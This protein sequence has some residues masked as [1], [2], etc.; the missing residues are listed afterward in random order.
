MKTHL[1]HKLALGLLLAG[2]LAAPAQIKANEQIYQKVLPG[3]VLVLTKDS[4]GTGVLVDAA[5]RRLITNYHVVR[6]ATEAH[7]FFPVKKNGNVVTDRMYYLQ[8]AGT[9]AIRGR[10]VARSVEADLAVIELD[11]LPEG[12]K[13]VKLAAAS[14]RPG[15]VLHAIGNP[16]TEPAM[17]LYATGK[18]RSVYKKRMVSGFAATDFRFTLDCRILATTIPVNPGD[19]GGPVVNDQGE[20]VGITQGW[21]PTSQQLGYAIDISEVRSF[22]SRA[23][24]GGSN[25]FA[26]IQDL[27]TNA[28]TTEPKQDAKKSFSL[29]G[30]WHSLKTYEN[31]NRVRFELQVK[32]SDLFLL[33]EGIETGLKDSIVGTCRIE[34]NRLVL[35]RNGQTENLGII[36]WVNAN[37]FTFQDQL[38]TLTFR[39]G[40]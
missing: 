31:G 17:W 26:K 13:E 24:S 25:T 27:L 14:T 39:K 11:R 4:G 38:I 18:T 12:A 33:V 9:L 19:S 36:T 40:S 15:Q 23:D 8:N 34:G 30:T 28:P 32:G 3:T 35:T 10:V 1:L 29:Q 6:D 37:E 20:L 5:K 22:L 7:V 2:A 16:G 21:L